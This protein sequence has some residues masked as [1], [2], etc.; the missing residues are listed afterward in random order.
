[1]ENASANRILMKNSDA[2]VLLV[3][4]ISLRDL[5]RASSAGQVRFANQIRA[6]DF[7]FVIFRTI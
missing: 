7:I 2:A 4:P 6:K 1:M 3:M 5:T